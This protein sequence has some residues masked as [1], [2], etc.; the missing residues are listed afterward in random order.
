MENNLVQIRATFKAAL[1]CSAI[2]AIPALA[3]AQDPAPVRVE[4]ACKT[5]MASLCAATDGKQ[6]RGIRCLTDNQAKLGAECATAIK[7]ARERRE[8]VQTA[9]KADADK[10]CAGA[11]PKGGQFVAC[12][13][14]KQA[15][16]SKPCADAIAA[17][18]Q[19]AAKQ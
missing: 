5:E 2:L 10:L 3:W 13:R 7:N 17:L 18:P 19:P 8:K 16:L 9:C 15:E 4:Q 11:Q 1:T 6:P 14:G 12:L